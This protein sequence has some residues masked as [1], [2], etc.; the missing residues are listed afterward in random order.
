MEELGTYSERT[1]IF[2]EVHYTR[3]Y[4]GCTK[5]IYYRS[6]FIGKTN[7]FVRLV[8]EKEKGKRKRGKEKEILE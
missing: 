2:I 3:I 8:R 6:K 4:E 7:L 1:R 5:Y